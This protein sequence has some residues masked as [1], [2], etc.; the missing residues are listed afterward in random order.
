M[1]RF[2][3]ALL[4]SL[5]LHAALLALLQGGRAESI[6][7]ATREKMRIALAVLPGARAGGGTAEPPPPQPVRT[8][9]QT[10]PPK[11]AAERRPEQPKQQTRPERPRRQAQPEQP[12]K[13]SPPQ[14]SPNS[15]RQN[16]I[17][18]NIGLPGASSAAA[19]APPSAAVGNGAVI[20]ASRLRV[21]KKV[22]AEYSAISR[23]RRDQGTVV[24]I[25][26]LKSGRVASVEV[27]KS[28]G[29]S[30]L[31]EAAKKAVSAWEF[32]VAGFGESLTVRIPYVFRLTGASPVM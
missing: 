15:P 21:T 9:P 10:T 31:D 3:L 12:K 30:A 28:S 11:P 13:I 7:R 20:D 27:E 1:R 19:A 17:A 32:D 6:P 14:E 4:L 18:E 16:G 26:R 24:L 2:A 25:L 29:H 23:R 8:E 5:A 22:Q